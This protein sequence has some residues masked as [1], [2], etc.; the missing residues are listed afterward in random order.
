VETLDELD[1]VRKLGCSHIQ[2]YIYSKPL[3]IGDA[4]ALF[5]NTVDNQAPGMV[6]EGP[7][8]AREVRRTMLRKVVLTHEGRA[9]NGTI[10]NISTRGA[11]VEGLWDV[12]E[13]VEFAIALAED[14]TVIARVKWSLHGQMG[15]EFRQKLL[16]DD[17]GRISVIRPLQRGHE[18][19]AG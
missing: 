13:G 15:V 2:G 6:A 17:G 11:M 19:Q 16:F 1:L 3:C 12:P 7:R 14:L 18:R 8:S 4:S 5:A 10:R 9:F